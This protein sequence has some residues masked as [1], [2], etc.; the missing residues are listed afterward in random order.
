[1]N[2][3]MITDTDTICA[4]S[5]PPGVGGIAVARVSGPQAIEI[6]QTLWKGRDLCQCKSHTAHLGEI[7]DCAGDTIDQGVATVFR[8]PA[9]YT[10][11]DVV[12]MAVHGS[13]YVQKCLI[14]ALICAGARLAEPGE[15]TR[16]AFLAGK[17]DLAQAE[18]VADVI[19]A[20]NRAAHQIAVSHMRGGYSQRLRGLR[21]QLLTLASLLELELDFSEE[22]VEFASRESLRA[23]AVDVKAEVDRLAASF[24]GGNAIKNGVPVAIVGATNAGKS[25]LL[26]ALLNDDRAIVSGIHGTT[27]DVIED[28]LRIGDFTIRIMDTAGMRETADEIES[29]GIQRSLRAAEQA[30]IVICVV[31]ASCPVPLAIPHTDAKIVLAV[32]KTDLVPNPDAEKIAVS[33]PHPAEATVNVSALTGD[34][35]DQLCDVIAQI[36]S[37]NWMGSASAMVTNVRH[38]QALTQASASI[39][40]VIEGLDANLSGD[41]IA[42]DL[43][44]TIHHL[45]SIIG[46]IST[47][48]ILQSIF[49]RFCVGK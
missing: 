38:Q 8:A 6:C 39:R 7:T 18:G 35:L 25:S 3:D 31:D 4:I 29:L 21:E 20:E 19:A 2:H 26:N 44:L 17:L 40:Q 33:L 22:D 14:D 46:D 37:D 42:L 12:E 30:M 49:S 32:N 41:L 27:R 24:R 28:T 45:S 16:R 48:E 36:I 13:V 15:F 1:M 43:R 9:S 34:G 5:T 47:P 23:L 11:E 10:G